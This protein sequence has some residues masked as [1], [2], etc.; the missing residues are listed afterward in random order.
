M[1]IIVAPTIITSMDDS[2]DISCFFGIGEEEEENENLKLLFE[3]NLELSDDFFVIKTNTNLIG[4][5][6]K[7]Y[8]KPHL[9][10]ISPPPEFI[11]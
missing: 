6:F 2:V 5:A 10:L 1:A 11:S 3:N 7:T 4:Y 8:P 9:N